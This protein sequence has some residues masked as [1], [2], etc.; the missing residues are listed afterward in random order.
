MTDTD[1]A[2][3]GATNSG[4]AKLDPM[5]VRALARSIWKIDAREKKVEVAKRK[6]DWEQK[7][8]GYLTQARKLM[9]QLKTERVELRM[10]E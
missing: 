6:E 2:T 1:T 3:G 4:E 9:R 8:A 7:R 5:L 10:G